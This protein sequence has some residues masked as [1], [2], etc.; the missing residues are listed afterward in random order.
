MKRKNTI[1]GLLK[2]SLVGHA[3][4]YKEKTSTFLKGNYGMKT[5]LEYLMKTS[6]FC[7]TGNSSGLLNKTSLFSVCRVYL[8]TRGKTY[9]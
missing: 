7:I 3:P 5:S 8:G 2:I 9:M 1:H 6:T 4:F